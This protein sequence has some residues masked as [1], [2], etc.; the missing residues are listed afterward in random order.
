MIDDMIIPASVATDDGE[1]DVAF[2]AAP[3]FDSLSADDILAMARHG[4]SS[5]LVA[6]RVAEM[7]ADYSEPVG[8]LFRYL[9]A[10]LQSA[11]DDDETGYNVFIDA[12]SAIEWIKGRDFRLFRDILTDN[13][14][15]AECGLDEDYIEQSRG[16]IRA[17][18][19]SERLKS[20]RTMGSGN[21]RDGG[22]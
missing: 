4:F 6:D 15:C 17:K 22:L 20:V 10:K 13:S 12:H 21:S 2:D 9:E 3:H 11:G 1:L 8:G 14:I 16:F 19:E 18:I 5:C 7:A